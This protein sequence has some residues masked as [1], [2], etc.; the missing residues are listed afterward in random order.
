M[1]RLFVYF[2]FI[3]LFVSAGIRA[4]INQTMFWYESFGLGCNQGQIAVGFTPTFTNGIWASSNLPAAPGNGAAA[5]EWFISATDAGRPVGTC[6]DGCLNNAGFTNRSLHVGA[7]LVAPNLDPGAIYIQS[8]TS[9]TR[10]RVESPPINCVGRN[11]IILN[12]NYM[13]I[14]NGTVDACEVVYS[15]A[16]GPW[17]SLGFLAPTPGPCAPTAQWTAT[18]YALPS[19]CD[20]VNN[21]RVGYVWTNTNVPGPGNIAVAIDDIMMTA[22]TLSYTVQSQVCAGAFTWA[23]IASNT[24]APTDSYT[25]SSSPGG[26]TF[27]P[28][29]VSAPAMTFPAPGIYTLTVAAGNLG[30]LTSS[31]SFTVNVVAQQTYSAWATPSVVCPNETTTLNCIGGSSHTWSPGPI[32]GT[33]V[34]ATPSV[35]TV[36][37]VNGVDPMN[38]CPGSGTVLVNMGQ[39]PL[40]SVVATASAVCV[41][42]SS[43]LTAAGAGSYTWSGTGIAPPIQS[44]SIV[45]GPGVYTVEAMTN[46]LPCAAYTV[47]NITLGSPL[48]IQVTT[49]PNTATTCIAAN[50]PM[51]SKPVNLCASGAGIYNWLPSSSL[52]YSIGPCVAARPLVTTCY[53]VIGNTSV[54]SGSAIV[55]VTVIPQFSMNVVPKQPYMCVGDS[56]KMYMTQITST[57]MPYAFNWVEPMNA[58]PP[59]LN[60]QL[61]QTVV[62]SPT[63]MAQPVTYSAE[64]IDGR[65]CASVPKYVPVTVLP[66]PLTAVALPIVNGVPINTICYV[67]SSTGSNPDALITLQATNSNSNILPVGVQ[68]TYTWVSPYAAPYSSPSIVVPPN[69]FTVVLAAP[70]R[71]P[72]LV[73]FSVWS[74]YNGIPV[75]GKGC[76]RVDTVTLRV[77]DCRSLSPTSTQF[78]TSIPNDTIC[79]RTCITFVNMTD[80][81]AGGP[82]TYTWTFAGGQPSVSNAMHPTVCYNL[83]G[84][85]NVV[86]RAA[87][88]YNKP[89][90]SFDFESRM[91]YIKVVDVPNPKILPKLTGG[92]KDTT[93]RYGQSITLT[94]TNCASYEWDP[95]YNISRTTGQVV[96][97]TPRKTT[98]YHL[99]GYASKACYA[100]DTINVIV[101][102]DC[103]ETFVPNAFSPNDDGVND[104]LKVRGYCLETMTFMIFNKWGEKVFETND[105]E[106][107]WDGTYKGDPMNTDVFV[108]RIE[109]ITFNGKAFSM[110]GN[111]TLIR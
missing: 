13:A 52:N 73:T 86:L 40:V 53:T 93:I 3:F 25:W 60:N 58:P 15:I 74:G 17:L 38:G 65:G 4:Q 24:V 84:N 110:K 107:G 54:C 12:F 43:T 109:G 11:N 99:W 50:Y 1:K 83:P 19:S 36:Y 18:N 47:V 45:V 8:A 34:L 23:P 81:A 10:K 62:I 55:C 101:L 22:P 78:T 41:G 57:Y 35:V 48:N 46:G 79:S 66:Q 51:T 69:D 33:P 75:D 90:G 94:G 42:F 2:L 6:G 80:T 88:P 85:Y 97:V 106:Q 92:R 20:G 31:L 111:V 61:S 103:G 32:F 21:L 91:N 26:V 39:F 7:N 44:S 95:N 5:N 108:Y 30:V 56:L 9:N 28:P 105:K 77:V 14:G 67:G 102:E 64:V 49:S 98:Q 82:Q 89:N 68:S 96:T 104:V 27:A 37:T 71:T 16:N 29:T 100:S 70:L 59:S 76:R 87:S 72:A 63:N